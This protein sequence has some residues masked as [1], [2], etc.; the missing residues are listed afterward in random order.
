MMG[1]M[2]FGTPG[3][4]DDGTTVWG[5]GDAGTKNWRCPDVLSS[6]GRSPVVLS[7]QGRCSVVPESRRPKNLPVLFALS[8]LLLAG[9][10]DNQ[11]PPSTIPDSAILATV[12]GRAIT[13][14]D[15]DYES[16]LRPGMTPDEILHE[17]IKRQALILRAEE[18]GIAETPALK[19]DLENRLI[20]EWLAGSYRAPR[21]GLSVTEDELRAAYED[22]REKIYTTPSQVR[23]A[24]YISSE[25]NCNRYGRSCLHK[26]SHS[27]SFYRK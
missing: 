11:T 27:E 15:F 16:A 20:S 3:Q 4:R 17:L 9:C 10:R 13:Q 19:R 6:Q 18:S 23:F 12:N 5:R 2:I 25:C 21:E 1:R 8:L 7:S 26:T 24:T 14:A 22:R